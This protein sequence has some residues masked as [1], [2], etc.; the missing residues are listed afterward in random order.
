M[1][2]LEP[3]VEG[4]GDVANAV[5]VVSRFTTCDTAVEVL[6]GSEDEPL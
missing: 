5:V 2:T 6:V 3:D 4:F 1:V